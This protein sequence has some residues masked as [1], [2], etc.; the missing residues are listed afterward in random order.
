MQHF[1]DI[2]VNGIQTSLDFL[3]AEDPTPP[4]PEAATMQGL[5]I[6]LSPHLSL[7]LSLRSLPTLYSI[8]SMVSQVGVY[9]HVSK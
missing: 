7:H 9:E 5:E 4:T 3:V 1:V 8:L 6:L 2:Y